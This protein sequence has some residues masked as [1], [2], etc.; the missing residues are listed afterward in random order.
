MQP[1]QKGTLLRIFL[2]EQEHYE[3]KPLYEQIVLQARQ[4]HLAGVTVLRGL[5][6]FGAGSHLHTAKL[7]RLSDDLPIVIE[8]IDSEEKISALLPFL[9]EVMDEGL[10]MMQEVQVM[11]YH[12]RKGSEE[13]EKTH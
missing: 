6:G 13:S 3:G 2:G 4:M 12:H 8:M 9:D 11:R 7:L 10:V 5:M 1:T